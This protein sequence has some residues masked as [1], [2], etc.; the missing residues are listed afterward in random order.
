[1]SDSTITVRRQVIAVS[2]LTDIQV[3]EIVEVDGVFQRAVRFFGS[4]GS[5]NAPAVLEVIVSADTT[6]AVEITAPERNF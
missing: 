3:T 4:P 2:E 6:A 5:T 1:M